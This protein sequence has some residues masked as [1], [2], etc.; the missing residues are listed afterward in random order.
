MS[1]LQR[2]Y[3][4]YYYVYSGNGRRR[5]L[6][7]VQYLTRNEFLEKNP[8]AVLAGPNPI[9]PCRHEERDF[10]PKNGK[11]RNHTHAR[12]KRRRKARNRSRVA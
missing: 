12:M 5:E 3:T 2:R 10:L 1:Q 6:I 7:K 9:F 8:M 11:K 4:D